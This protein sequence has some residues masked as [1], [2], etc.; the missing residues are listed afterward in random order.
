MAEDVPA[1]FI[2]NEP[3]TLPVIKPGDGTMM[4]CHSSIYL[5]VR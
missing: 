1:I 5:F 2:R 3:E 4:F